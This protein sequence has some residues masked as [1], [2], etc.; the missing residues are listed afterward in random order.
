MGD[1]D[2]VGTGVDLQHLRVTS[3]LLDV[4]LGHVAVAAVQLHGLHLDA[5]WFAGIGDAIA[6]FGEVRLVLPAERDTRVA[7]LDSNARWRWFRSRKPLAA[8]A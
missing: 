8:H 5:R 2:L 3:K 7:R 1:L 6:R 4:E